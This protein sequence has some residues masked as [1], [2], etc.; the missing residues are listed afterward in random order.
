VA[1]EFFHS[2]GAGFPDPLF[3]HTYPVKVTKVKEL[4]EMNM[5]IWGICLKDVG[6][7]KQFRTSIVCIKF[8]YYKHKKSEI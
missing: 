8:P 2:P 5:R 4:Y 3:N 6:L 7:Q 1:I